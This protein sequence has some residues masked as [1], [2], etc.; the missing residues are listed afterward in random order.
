MS[1]QFMGDHNPTSN[2]ILPSPNSLFIGLPMCFATGKFRHS[3]DI[4]VIF[5]TPLY[6]HGI[7][8]VLL[9]HLVPPWLYDD[10]QI[11]LSSISWVQVSAI[12]NLDF[13]Q[14]R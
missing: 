11:T 14:S 13:R 8:V 4:S 2:C 7:V 1:S 5:V 10:T 9:S 6:I 3:D 12:L